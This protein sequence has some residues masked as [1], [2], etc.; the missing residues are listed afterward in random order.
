MVMMTKAVAHSKLS[1]SLGLGFPTRVPAQF[2][3]KPLGTEIRA[4]S[5]DIT[6]WQGDPKQLWGQME[7][8]SYNEWFFMSVPIT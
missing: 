3:S 1:T 2:L 7:K 5:N 6:P 8:G 4:K